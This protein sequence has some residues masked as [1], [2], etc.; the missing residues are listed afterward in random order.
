M[1]MEEVAS[2]D[3]LRRAFERVASN[4]G[5]PG[6]DR[7]SVDEV[8]EHLDAVLPEL[9]RELLDGSH[10]PGLIRRVWI[11]KSGGGERG[12]GI[13]NRARENFAQHGTSKP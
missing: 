13:P 9:H 1:T 6:P 2:Q 10:R 7:Q 4:K 12:L 5:A 11:P 8:R 3:N